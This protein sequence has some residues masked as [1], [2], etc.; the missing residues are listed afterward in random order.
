MRRAVAAWAAGGA[1][2]CA[3]ARAGSLEVRVT[4]DAGAGVADVAVIAEPLFRV[5]AKRQP[6][7]V[8]EQQNREFRPYLTIVQTGTAIEF[9]NSDPVKHHVYSFSPAKPFEIKLYAGKPMQPVVFDKPGDVALGCNIHDWMEAYVL[10]VDTPY[11]AKTSAAGLAR[12]EQLPAGRYR[13]RLWH[14]RQLGEAPP[15]A[16]D[17]GAQPLGLAL[18]LAVAPHV[19]RPRPPSDEDY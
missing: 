4:T 12:L 15:R 19:P 1:L 5:A 10:V 2:F 8:I 14:P 6:T 16:I 7:A 3:G 9:P 11:F 13:L 17:I 18:R